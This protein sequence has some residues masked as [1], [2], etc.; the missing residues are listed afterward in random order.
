MNCSS[1]KPPES[2][3]AIPIRNAYV[4]VPPASPVVSVSRKSHF[5]GSSAAARH[6]FVRAASGVRHNRS[7]AAG[8]N[9]GNSGVAYQ[10]RMLRWFP[11]LVRTIVAPSS[12][13]S[14]H[15]SRP[16]EGDSSGDGWSSRSAVALCA[17]RSAASRAR[18]RPARRP[19][20]PCRSRTRGR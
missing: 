15:S 3:H 7:N 13:A 18:S 8:R 17:G 9:S 20:G 1:C 12:L 16:A 19:R 14:V 4:P 5:S 6:F 10:L 11:Y 2:H